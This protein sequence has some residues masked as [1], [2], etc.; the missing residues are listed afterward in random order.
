VAQLLFSYGTLRQPDV[1]RVLFGREV[2]TRPDAL[3]GFVLEWVR[4]SDPQVIA[5]SGSDRHPILRPG[6]AED[7]V[8]GACLEL[9]EAELAAADGYEVEDY[10][11]TSVV[12]ASGVNAWVY[13]AAP[14]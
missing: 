4:I 8:P 14:T 3:P 10:A 1:Q 2:P 7:A 11:R 12:L 5:T 6:A 13:L 9:S